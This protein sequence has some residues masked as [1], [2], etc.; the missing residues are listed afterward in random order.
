[1]NDKTKCPHHETIGT[2]VDEHHEALFDKD[3][4]LS[5]C[6]KDKVSIKAMTTWVIIILGLLSTF[7]LAGLNAW[8]NAKDER[9]DN[10]TAIAVIHKELE[11]I[12]ESMNEIK[13]KQIDSKDLLREIRKIVNEKGKDK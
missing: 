10:K 3:T 13:S 6:I 4:G 2:K 1:M 12:N 8:G 7:T 11:S 9:K 5:Y